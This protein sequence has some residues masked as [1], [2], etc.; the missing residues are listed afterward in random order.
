MAA[1]SLQQAQQTFT[2]RFSVS[3]R[4]TE[5]SRRSV[6]GGYSRNSFNFGPHAVFVTGG[7]GAYID[8]IDGHRLLDLNNNYT[9][10][11][12]GHHHP[13]LTSALMEAIPAGIS[14]GN[15]G[16]QEGDLARMIIERIPSVEKVQFSCSAT[17]SCMTAVRLARATTGRTHIAKFEGGYHGFSDVLQ[18]SAHPTPENGGDAAAPTAVPDSG[19]IPE[20]NTDN[21]LVLT[22]NDL[23]G[24]E[25]LLRAHSEDLACVIMELQSGAGGMVVLDQDFVQMLRD[26]TR[27][28]GI[29]LIFDETI[30]LRAG[31]S[32]LQG[33]YGITPD[34]TVMGKIIGGGLPLGAVGGRAEI[35]DALED[36]RASISGTHHGHKLSVVAGAACLAELTEDAFATLNGYARRI[37]TEL[38]AWSRERNSPFRIHGRG[39]S[40]LGYAYMTAPGEAVRTHRDYWR[41]VD[42]ERTQ[43]ISLELA[44]RGYFPVHRGEMSLSLAMTDEDIS[45][46]I[47]TLKSIVSNMEPDR[48][49]DD[50]GD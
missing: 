29:V 32:G 6:P 23:A 19:G 45:G 12:L 3:G 36:G 21:V 18:I 5:E 10:N 50:A 38:N 41:V 35:M 34:L 28:L 17:E 31:Y 13:A 25:S 42:G 24:T 44:N 27:E 26:V 8:T 47:D 9:V 16:V 4:M 15:P 22:Q 20:S 39:F 40:H 33:Q 48:V 46:L 43:T 1:L 7:E 49:S 2:E 37:T 11:V 30:S 14:F